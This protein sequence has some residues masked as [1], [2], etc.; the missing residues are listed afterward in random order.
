MTVGVKKKKNK[1]AGAKAAV[2]KAAG[3]NAVSGPRDQ[4]RINGAADLGA[5]RQ[6]L[7][8]CVTEALTRYFKALDGELPVGL[9]E[10][11]MTEVERPL[12]AF[13]MHELGGNQSRAAEILGLNRGTLRKK[14]NQHGLLGS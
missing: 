1:T 3:A 7:H 13:V 2:A 8:Q 4:S 12:L 6:P 10:L 9:Y 5:E 11:V 14:L